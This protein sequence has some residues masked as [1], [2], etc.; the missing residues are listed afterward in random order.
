MT[1]GLFVVV[2]GPNGAGKST[3]CRQLADSLRS[4]GHESA[5][6]SEPSTRDIGALVRKYRELP[7]YKEVLAFLLMADRHANLLECVEPLVAKG[8]VVISDRYLPSTLVY[9]ALDGLT[10]ERILELNQGIRIPDLTILLSTPLD[11]VRDRVVRRQS[12]SPS[13]NLERLEQEYILYQSIADRLG[14]MGHETL[15]VPGSEDGIRQ[16]IG[17]LKSL[18]AART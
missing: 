11:V 16:A 17:R 13:E 14:Q 15:C 3:F 9:Q 5:L 2:E 4:C 7:Q 1:E 18:L 6:I 8:V 10:E 12:N